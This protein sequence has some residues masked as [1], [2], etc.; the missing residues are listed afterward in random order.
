MYPASGGK[1]KPMTGRA[2][3]RLGPCAKP[4]S[5]RTR[6]RMP[7]RAGTSRRPRPSWRKATQRVLEPRGSGSSVPGR[8]E[9]KTCLRAQPAVSPVVANRFLNGRIRRRGTE[10]GQRHLCAALTAQFAW[11]KPNGATGGRAISPPRVC[12]RHP[13]FVTRAILPLPCSHALASHDA[14]SPPVRGAER[15]NRPFVS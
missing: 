9:P 6:S 13:E 2:A 4:I 12:P 7:L 5:G 8:A 11:L 10:A 1:V 3:Q 15:P 14:P